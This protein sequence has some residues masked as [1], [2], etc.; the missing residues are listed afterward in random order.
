MFSTQ[1]GQRLGYFHPEGVIPWRPEEEIPAKLFGS[2]KPTRVIPSG[3]IKSKE[4]SGLIYNEKIRLKNEIITNI[5]NTN[6]E[7]MWCCPEA[8]LGAVVVTANVRM[9]DSNTWQQLSY[10]LKESAIRYEIYCFC[11]HYT[12]YTH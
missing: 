2:K 11:T 3:F 4:N 7:I 5:I 12:F 10:S 9:R 1:S 8:E 6:I